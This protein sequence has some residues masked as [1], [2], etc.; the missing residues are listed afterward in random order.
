MFSLSSFVLLAVIAAHAL[1]VPTVDL[2][3]DHGYATSGDIDLRTVLAAVTTRKGQTFH[4][5]STYNTND[6]D[7]GFTADVFSAFF[8]HAVAE[9]ECKWDA[10]EPSPGTSDLKECQIVQSFAAGTN[11]SFRGHNTFWHSQLPSWLPGSFSASDVVNTIIPAHVQQE[12]QGMGTSVTSWDVVN[13]VVGDSTTSEMSALQCVQNKNAWPTVTS[14]GSGTALVS[15]LSFLHAAFS[16]AFKFAGPNTRLAINDYGTGGDDAKTACNIAVLKDVQANTNIPFNRLAVGFQS[17][18]SDGAFTSKAALTKTFSTL[19]DLGVEAML[20]ELDVSL[21]GTAEENLRFQAAIWGDYLDAC[22]YA[23]NCNEFINWDTRDDVSWLG[24]DKAGTLFDSNGSPK[25]AA[26]E[27]AARLMHYSYG[28]DELCATA[29]GTGSCTV[30]VTASGSSSSAAGVATAIAA[31]TTSVPAAEITSAS[32]SG[33]TTAL[34]GQCGGTGFTG[35][36][37]CA[38]GSTCKFSNNY[39]S[40]CL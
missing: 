32:S 8:N 25:P 3:I 17:H 13:E 20:T 35:C 30:D 39:Y 28:L 23:S 21:S 5:G 11:A 16:T 36:T 37:T 10:T 24:E 18:V 29:L 31:L 40:Q 9:N 27:V 1:A 6:A 15:D 14:D 4:F 7:A 34:Y 38:S 2:L 33:C 12:V 22:L 19:A 26:Y